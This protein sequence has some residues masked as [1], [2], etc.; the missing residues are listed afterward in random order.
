MEKLSFDKKFKDLKQTINQTR[1][2]GKVAMN[3]SLVNTNTSDKNE[4][5]N[6]F[7][8]SL[9]MKPSRNWEILDFY[10]AQKGLVN[11]LNRDLAYNEEVMPL[12]KASEIANKFLCLFDRKNSNYFSNWRLSGHSWDPLTEATFDTGIIVLDNNRIGILWFEDE[13]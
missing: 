8:N 6:S 2:V 4:L 12:D 1:D 7:V 9:G 11:V 13:D 3:F 10:K 5:V